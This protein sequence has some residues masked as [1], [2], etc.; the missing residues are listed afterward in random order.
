MMP[1]A[2]KQLEGNP[3][4]FQYR[5]SVVVHIAARRN[6]VPSL[7]RLHE[8]FDFRRSKDVPVDTRER[9]YLLKNQN[10]L[11]IC[12]GIACRSGARLAARDKVRGLRLLLYGKHGNRH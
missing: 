4:Q 8:A 3:P 6:C 11:L 7:S 9:E 10:D 2:S 5:I 1:S 12:E